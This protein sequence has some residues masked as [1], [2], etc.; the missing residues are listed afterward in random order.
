[1]I[2]TDKHSG[3]TRN[4]KRDEKEVEFGNL[5]FFLDVNRQE[6]AKNKNANNQ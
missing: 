2:K 6:R 1:M 3:E 5:I 4:V